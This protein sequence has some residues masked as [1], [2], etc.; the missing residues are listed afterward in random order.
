MFLINVILIKS[1]SVNCVF[2][3]FSPIFPRFYAT[4]FKKT[5]PGMRFK[6][7]QYYML[8]QCLDSNYCGYLKS[9]LFEGRISNGWALAMCIVMS[10]PLENQTI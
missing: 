8:A 9:I 7:R 1:R 10:Q 4:V 6:D 3:E 2:H 5:N